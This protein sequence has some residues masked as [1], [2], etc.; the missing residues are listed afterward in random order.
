MLHIDSRTKLAHNIYIKEVLIPKSVFR[1][2]ASFMYSTINSTNI[3]NLYMFFTKLA[4]E[5]QQVNTT[6]CLTK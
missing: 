5:S 4:V 6:K 2:I 3:E 1:Y